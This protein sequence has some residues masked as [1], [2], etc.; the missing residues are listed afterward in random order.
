MLNGRFLITRRASWFTVSLL[1]SL[2]ASY[3]AATIKTKTLKCI[4]K[5]SAAASPPAQRKCVSLA[6]LIA[7]F[8]RTPTGEML[9]AIV[10][11]RCK[12]NP[13]GNPVFVVPMTGRSR[14]SKLYI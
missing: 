10:F 3:K 6:Q 5:V 1:F 2:S 12:I 9:G 13:V 4:E 14:I 8:E 11:E 7:S